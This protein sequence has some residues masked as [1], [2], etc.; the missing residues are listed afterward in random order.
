MGC[1]YPKDCLN[2][3]ARCIHLISFSAGEQGKVGRVHLLIEMPNI[4][5]VVKIQE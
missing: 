5:S 1:R 3:C 2:H 4:G